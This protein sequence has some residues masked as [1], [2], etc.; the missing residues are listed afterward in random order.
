MSVENKNRLTIRE[1]LKNWFD[2][3]IEPTQRD[4]DVYFSD[5]KKVETLPADFAERYKAAIKHN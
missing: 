2:K 4:I 3:A 1:R 5:S